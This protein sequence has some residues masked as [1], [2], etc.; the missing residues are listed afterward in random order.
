MNKIA[1]L[2]NKWRGLVEIGHELYKDGN[3]EG[4]SDILDAMESIEKVEL[5][6][7]RAQTRAEREA[8]AA[9]RRADP[10]D[11]ARVRV[12][13]DAP[14][15]WTNDPEHQARM[16][17]SLLRR[18]HEDDARERAEAAKAEQ[19]RAQLVAERQ[20]TAIMDRWREDV[21]LG[22]ATI[23]DLPRYQEAQA[24]R[25]HAE[26]LAAFAAE[27]DAED[28]RLRA[29]AT[30]FG[31]MCVQVFGVDGD[32]AL[33]QLLGGDDKRAPAGRRLAREKGVA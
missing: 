2:K 25:T 28:A 17:P 9:A 16:S 23:H 29:A 30:R 13:E 27:Q 31:A 1:Y 6:R 24:G 11:V 26:A 19:W 3:V 7:A 33:E 21:A 8:A 4:V 10:D 32:K 5:P 22:V 12:H 14:I 18:I 15:G 20:E